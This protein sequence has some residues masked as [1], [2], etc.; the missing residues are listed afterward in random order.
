VFLDCVR[1]RKRPPTD[2]EVGHHSTNVGHLM[3]LAWL[4]G[5]RIRWDGEQERVIGDEE[6]NALVMKPYRDPW[7]LEV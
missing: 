6:A 5:R 3:N 4:T 1:E 2:V 7:K